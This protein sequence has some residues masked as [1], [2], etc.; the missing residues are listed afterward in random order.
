MSTFVV[1]SNEALRLAGLQFFFYSVLPFF[2]AYWP[3]KYNGLLPFLPPPSFPLPSLKYLK[4]S[5][6]PSV[7]DH[8]PRTLIQSFWRAY[9]TFWSVNVNM[10]TSLLNWDVPGWWGWERTSWRGVLL[11]SSRRKSAPVSE[12]HSSFSTLV[13]VPGNTPSTQGQL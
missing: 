4:E 9:G 13:F 5:S 11:L 8:T 3:Q 1:K 12:G 2:R 7:T 6:S 10:T